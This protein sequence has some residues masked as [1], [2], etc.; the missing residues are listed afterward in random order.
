MER[1]VYILFFDFLK[2]YW[3]KSRPVS[4]L[5]YGRRYLDAA[6]ANIQRLLFASSLTNYYAQIL[7]SIKP[8]LG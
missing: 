2:Q 1:Q 4:N 7:L 8:K 5:A 6:G 3:Q